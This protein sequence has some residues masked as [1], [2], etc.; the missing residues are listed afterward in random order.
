MSE[1]KLDRIFNRKSRR[2]R[3]ST[4]KK[5][6]ALADGTGGIDG[7]SDIRTYSRGMNSIQEVEEHQESASIIQNVNIQNVKEEIT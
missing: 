5:E 3:E 6:T 7:T 2:N 4:E 1:T